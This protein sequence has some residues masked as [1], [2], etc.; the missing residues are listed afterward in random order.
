M[1]KT[2]KQIKEEKP[3]ECIV[4][5]DSEDKAIHLQTLGKL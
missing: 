3:E 2:K 5:E 4:Y 1:G